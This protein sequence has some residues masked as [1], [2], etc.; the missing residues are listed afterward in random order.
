MTE[1]EQKRRWY[2]PVPGHLV[3]VL[4]AVEAILLLSN[5]RGWFTFNQ[6]KGWTV[7][8]AVACVSGFLVLM[9]FWFIVS[10]LFRWRFQFSIRSLLLLTLVIAIPS[11]WFAV[12]MKKSRDQNAIEKEV[13]TVDRDYG[14]AVGPFWVQQLLGEDFFTSIIAIR[15]SEAT[16]ERLAQIDGFDRLQGLDLGG[17]K[18]TD[19]GLIHLRGMAQLQWLWLYNT[20]ISDAGLA[21]LEELSQLEKL[22][23]AGTKTTDA[24]VQHLSGMFR[25]EMLDLASTRI[26]DAGLLHLRRLSRLEVLDLSSNP[27]TGAGLESLKGLTQLRTLRIANTEV[28]DRGLTCLHG[29][30][31]LKTLDL[32][33]SKTT[34]EG[35]EKLQQALANCR[36][37]K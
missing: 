30:T 2:R 19:A 13:W 36:I 22:G 34:E 28:T 29:L 23:L 7:L 26:T 14:Q 11:S 37:T 15:F 17:T 10:L 20:E 24:G 3:A 1:C 8:I 32:T 33:A 16:D 27:I 9:S 5:W 31:N 6:Y 21:H 18:I 35:I 4:L 12:E 25:L